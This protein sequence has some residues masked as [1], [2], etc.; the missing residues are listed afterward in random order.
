MAETKRKYDPVKRREYYLRTREL[1]GRAKGKGS[2]IKTGVDKIKKE[3]AKQVRLATVKKTREKLKLAWNNIMEQIR[4]NDNESLE[5]GNVFNQV[6]LYNERK[7][8]V[9]Q[10]EVVSDKMHKI[11]EE[12]FRLEYLE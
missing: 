10:L 1:K 9:K 7:K 8:L 5:S 11:S 2:F 12:E 6:N 4:L 3:E